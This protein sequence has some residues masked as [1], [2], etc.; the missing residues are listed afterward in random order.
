MRPAH[1]PKVMLQKG[2]KLTWREKLKEIRVR[3]EAVG[4][5]LDGC[6]FEAK[7]GPRE[8]P[9]A[10]QSWQGLNE[11]LCAYG[12]YMVMDSC[13]CFPLELHVNTPL[14]I[15]AYRIG[16]IERPYLHLTKRKYK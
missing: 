14:C 5:N 7:S 10:R 8:R 4:W 16:S 3:E 11:S 1:S 13:T 15:I 9:T 6:S 12:F 2:L